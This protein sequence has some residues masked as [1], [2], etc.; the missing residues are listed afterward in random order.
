MGLRGWCVQL[1]VLVTWGA[2]AGG[3]AR[4]DVPDA[5]GT[6][7]AC[8]Q[9]KVGNLRTIDPDAGQTCRPSEDPLDWSATGSGAEG[10]PGPA[11]P[12]GPQGPQGPAGSGGAPDVWDATGSA[13][14]NFL[15]TV[16]SL[17]LPAGSYFVI[18]KASIQGGGGYTCT[19]VDSAGTLD[20]SLTVANALATVPVQSTVTLVSDDTVSL[21][22][23]ATTNPAGVTGHLD[24]IQIGTI[25]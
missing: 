24:A 6:I 23:T 21:K 15:T 2:C 18:G 5:G 20:T 10:P 7:H 12:A 16:V 4:A 11:G 13:T 8:I 1:A 14:V 3:V 17:S 19:L 22:C 25:H 9:K